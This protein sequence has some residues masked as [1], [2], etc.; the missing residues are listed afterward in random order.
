VIQAGKKWWNKFLP[1]HN[2]EI[3]DLVCDNCPEWRLMLQHAKLIS[4]VIARNEYSRKKVEELAM[5]K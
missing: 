3:E 5:R 4:E 2:P 1:L